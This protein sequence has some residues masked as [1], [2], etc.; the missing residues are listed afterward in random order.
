MLRSISDSSS[1]MT[2][3]TCFLLRPVLSAM[4]AIIWLLVI[5]PLIAG[6]AFLAGAAFFL[7]AA[8]L[9]AG[10]FLAATFFFLAGAFF[11]FAAAFLVAMFVRTFPKFLDG[12][13][14]VSRSLLRF[15]YRRK[16]R[17]S[18]ARAKV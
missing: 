18:R 10:A 8:F 6:A 7:A 9:R 13:F 17:L 14:S 1:P 15:P 5:L 11:F 12:L 2:S 16:Q 3:P 4:L